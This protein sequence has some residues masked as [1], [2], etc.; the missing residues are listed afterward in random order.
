MFFGIIAVLIALETALAVSALKRGCDSPSWLKG[1]LVV[2]ALETALLVGLALMPFIYM[3]F[4][5]TGAIVTLC[6][7]LVVA[8]IRWL[9]GRKKPGVK[10]KSAVV[11]SAVLTLLLLVP[12]LMPVLIFTNYN[13][14]PVAGS[15][16]IASCEAIL[17]D[18]A[19]PDP[20]E[21]DGSSR[22][23]PVHF[24]YPEDGGEYPLVVF[25]HGAFGYYQSNYST[26][27]ELAGSGYVVAALDHPHHAFFCKDSDGKL[28]TV[29]TEFLN[30]A[31][32]LSERTPDEQYAL[33]K[34]WMALRTAD[35]DLVLDSVCEA[36]AADALGSAWRASDKEE[37][38]AVIRM[39]DTSRIGVM[40]HS[41]G[42]ATAVAAGRTRSDVDAVIVLD[43]TMLGEIA[44]YENGV[45][46][47]IE[48]A[49]PVPILDFSKS[50]DYS[51]IESA[52]DPE[53]AFFL[54]NDHVISNAAEGRRIMC[55]D[56]GHMD[57]TDLPLFSPF[58]ANLL[59]SGS[60][61]KA[62]FMTYI[63]GMVL[64][65]FDHY[66]KGIE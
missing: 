40:G 65:W 26:Y 46:S 20:F 18:G 52:D 38:L 8:L 10:K 50:S 24:Y 66:L 17:V 42:G 58:L 32:N 6:I 21:S 55:D 28:V 60:A 16:E 15:H 30:N 63:N 22:E 31:M 56:V 61:D 9:A 14:L 49:Y 53:A 2:R 62:E 37:V 59:G 48:E 25:S 35:M 13:G 12:A 1:R 34:E 39:T 4:R 43:G 11:M 27:A 57:F 47:Y 29:D 54:V 5:F 45:C 7:L 23:V 3:K 44:G 36:K 33:F 41:M 64:G 51:D 19:R